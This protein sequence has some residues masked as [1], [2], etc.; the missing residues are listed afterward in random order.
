MLSRRAA[1]V[2]RGFLFRLD[3]DMGL[4][5]LPVVQDGL[6]DAGDFLCARCARRQKTCCQQTD[7]FVTLGDVERIAEH[8]GRRDFIEPRGARSPEYLDQDDDPLWR[9]TVFRPDGTRRV[10]KKRPNDDCSFLG[11]TGCVLPLETR[12][13]I[14]RLYPYDYTEAGIDDE[15]GDYCP[16]YLLPPGVG[17]I[18][19]LDMRRTDAERWHER[20]YAELREERDAALPQGA[21]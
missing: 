2:G 3:T 15:L 18:E 10:L 12:P 13:L 9:D 14:C 16:I 19:A 4:Q 8:V 5:P 11:P 6:D 21:D 20:L 17:L 7:I 1:T